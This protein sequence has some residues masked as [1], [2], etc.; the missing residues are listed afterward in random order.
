MI[1]GLTFLIGL[2]FLGWAFFMSDQIIGSELTVVIVLALLA[3]KLFGHIG[4]LVVVGASVCFYIVSV[5]VNASGSILTFILVMS[6]SYMA[7]KLFAESK[8]G[9]RLAKAD[10]TK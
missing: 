6:V 2:I 5:L 10:K 3:S 9:K 8:L 1:R 7:A 4:F